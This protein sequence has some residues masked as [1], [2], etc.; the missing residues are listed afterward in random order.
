MDNVAYSPGGD[1]LNYLFGL[2]SIYQPGAKF[3][4]SSG[5]SVSLGEVLHRKTDLYVDE[6]CDQYI[7]TPM[8]I[9]DYSWIKYP[10]GM[11]HTGGGLSLRGRDL[12]K[13]GQLFLDNGIW[14]EKRILSEEWV[15][16]S[17]QALISVFANNDD[18]QY[19]M[20]WWIDKY[21]V[22]GTVY[23]SFE[24]RG[25]GGQQVIAIKELDLVVTFTGGYYGQDSNKPIRNIMTN[26]II[27][28]CL[29][30]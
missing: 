21:P 24:T 18:V 9:T 17:T 13:F 8:Q 2:D 14:N 23:E 12:M 16:L 20:Q 30:Q 6:F 27:P 22:G 29:N 5:F 15:S 3:A 28:A 1:P 19:G 4:Y 10:N 11:P 25:N 7:F 26:Y